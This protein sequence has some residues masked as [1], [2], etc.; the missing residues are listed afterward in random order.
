MIAEVN[1]AGSAATD[2]YYTGGLLR[3]RHNPMSTVCFRQACTRYLCVANSGSGVK[4]PPCNVTN[5]DESKWSSR[6]VSLH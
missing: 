2:A 3:T 4:R 6:G 5:T 1:L